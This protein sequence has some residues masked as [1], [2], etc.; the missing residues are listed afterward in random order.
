M[1]DDEHGCAKLTVTL[2]T[3]LLTS[4]IQMASRLRLAPSQIVECA[5][6]DFLT[7]QSRSPDDP[8]PPNDGRPSSYIEMTARESEEAHDIPALPPPRSSKVDFRP[9]RAPEPRP[10]PGQGAARATSASSEPCFSRSA[11]AAEA[12]A[13][14]QARRGSLVGRIAQ[15]A[16]RDAPEL[17]PKPD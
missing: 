3:D 11:L 14:E 6:R 12:F 7:R 5:C 13:Q 1:T 8:S 4:L 2:P 16:G 17:E 15:P 10:V 9:D